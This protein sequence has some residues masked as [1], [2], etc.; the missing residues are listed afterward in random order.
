MALNGLQGTPKEGDGEAVTSNWC[1]VV[2]P[3]HARGKAFPALRKLGCDVEDQE[4]MDGY[5]NSIYPY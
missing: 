1:L 2:N 5:V 3:A 4:K